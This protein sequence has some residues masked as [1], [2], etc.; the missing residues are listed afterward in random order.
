MNQQAESPINHISKKPI[1]RAYFCIWVIFPILLMMLNPSLYA[2]NYLG[3]VN[4]APSV[5]DETLLNEGFKSIVYKIQKSPNPNLIE[6]RAPSSQELK[7]VE[8]ANIILKT[9]AAKAIALVDGNEIVY[10][11]FKSPANKKSIFYTASIAKTV[12]SMAIGQAICLNKIKITDKAQD[13]IDE[14]REKPLG[15]ATVKDLLTM[16]AGVVDPNNPSMKSSG[17]ILSNQDRIEWENDRLN[18]INVISRD[19]VAGAAK[20]VFSN[21]KPGERFSYNNVN[22]LTLGIIINKA[23]GMNYAQWVQKNVLDPAGIADRGFI[24]QD[25]FGHASADG[26]YGIRLT[27]DDW[28]RFAIWVRKSMNSD[29][30][31]AKY[32]KQASTR[33]INNGYSYKDRRTEADFAGYGYLIW[34]ENPRAAN[35]FWAIGYGGQKIGWNHENERIAV[36]FSNIENWDE[37]AITLYRDWSQIRN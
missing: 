29:D 13:W 27:M 35:T 1:H 25:K 14:L 6:I 23:T 20:G 11:G 4:G 16:S 3:A 9:T 2:Q 31:F 32:I 28:I 21:F 19:D 12:T 8:A 30:C 10:Q 15:M 37:K 5:G 36:M 26:V 17:N 7:V 33:Q 24:S 18:F 22:A 34:T